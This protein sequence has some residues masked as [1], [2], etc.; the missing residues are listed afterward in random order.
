MSARAVAVIRPAPNIIAQ[1]AFLCILSGPG[2][3]HACEDLFKGSFGIF[4]AD[5]IAAIAV[6]PAQVNFFGHLVGPLMASFRYACVGTL[7]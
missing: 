1:L 4:F 7:L 6:G 2:Q 5:A 3:L